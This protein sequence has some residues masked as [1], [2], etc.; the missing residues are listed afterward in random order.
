MLW[1][2]FEMTSMQLASSSDF[3]GELR[4]CVYLAS[5]SV[6]NA[7]LGCELAKNITIYAA[8]SQCQ[9]RPWLSTTVH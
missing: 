2:N 3:C 5:T 1:K 8:M 4:A 9:D 6:A 7:V